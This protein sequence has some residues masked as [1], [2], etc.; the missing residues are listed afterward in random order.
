MK[1]PTLVRLAQWWIVSC[2][3]VALAAVQ[4]M[5]VYFGTGGGGAKGIY[6][7]TF[8]PKTGKLTAAE[9]AAEVGNPGFLAG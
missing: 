3:A 8:D 4:A 5:P 9:L 1:I 6:R 2:G 7:A